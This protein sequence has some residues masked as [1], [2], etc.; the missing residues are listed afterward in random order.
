MFGALLLVGVAIIFV[1]NARTNAW[2][3]FTLSQEFTYLGSAQ[4]QYGF[5]SS[6]YGDMSSEMNQLRAWPRINSFAQS[7]ALFCQQ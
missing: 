4:V 2:H 6:Y 1:G 5:H 7:S 3:T